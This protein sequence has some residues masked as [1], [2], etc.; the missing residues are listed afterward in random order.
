MCESGSADEGLTCLEQAT[1]GDSGN[2]E[3][4][5]NLG[6]A[7]LRA[8]RPE[9]ALASFDRALKLDPEHVSALNNRGNALMDL[10][11]PGPAAES[12]ERA[13]QRQPRHT[14]ACFNLAGIRFQQGQLAEAERGFRRT[15]SLT[16]NH[17]GARLA[18]G[19]V[20]LES[21]R[22]REAVELLEGLVRDEPDNAPAR[23][24]LGLALAAQDRFDDALSAHRAAAKAQP[25]NADH[26]NNAGSVLTTLGRL[27]EAE[28]ALKC[29]LVLEPEHPQAVAN[30]AALYEL[31][32]QTEDCER[33]ISEALERQPSDPALR[34]IRAKLMIRGGQTQAARE[35]LEALTGE[36]LPPQLEKDAWFL[37]A[38]ALDEAADHPAAFNAYVEANRRSLARWR[39]DHPESDTLLPALDDLQRRLDHRWPKDWPAADGPEASDSPV[40]LMGFQ[41]SGTTLIDTMLGAHPAVH[42]MEELPVLNRVVEFLDRQWGNRHGH[43]PG[44]LPE[45]DA[46]QRA[47]LRGR[48]RALA[49]ELSGW[50]PQAGTR[51]VDK[52]PLAAMHLGLIQR[53][54]PN[55]RIVQVLRHPCDVV[56][57]CFMQDFTLTP[58]MAHYTTLEGVA[59]VY[60][61]LMGLWRGFTESLALSV[62]VVRYEEL[63]EDTEGQLRGLLDFLELDWQA[64]VLDHT[65]YA[66]SRGVIDSPSF[67]QVTQPVYRDAALRWHRHRQ[68][69]ET[70]LPVLQPWIDR[71]GYAP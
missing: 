15:L 46:T 50:T 27:D 36:P 29:A 54:Y 38:K 40:F 22:S 23:S 48:Y 3:A 52:K 67:S 66:R 32:G 63:V 53:M 42:V 10:G 12:F 51:L 21:H 35:L 41:R 71:Y 17:S 69:L 11:Q 68:P 1:T 47:S 57:S 65:R 30:L 62:H 5:Y 59:R 25:R 4:W 43:Y 34:L 19:R 37:L 44:S 2:P 70:V 16:P 8:E 55:A 33:V 64:D 39:A 6:S 61:R 28:T 49:E 31:Q 58:F 56:L 45:L 9:A 60:D 13:L 7:Q 18:L 20:L 26:H 14:G 24:T